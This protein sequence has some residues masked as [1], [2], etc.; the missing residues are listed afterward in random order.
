MSSRALLAFVAMAASVSLAACAGTTAATSPEARTNHPAWLTG[1][2]EATGWQ[3]AGSTTQF[4]RTATVTFAPD[5]TWQ[6]NAGDSGTSWLTGGTVYVEGQT[7]DG[8]K[9][10]YSLKERQVADGSRELWAAI[11]ARAG[12]TELSLKQVR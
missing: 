8:F 9:F 11:E 2:W 5:G 1:T 3:S 6:S 7:K 12:A 4:Q 10:Q